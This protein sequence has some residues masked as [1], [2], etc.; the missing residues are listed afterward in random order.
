MKW[1]TFPSAEV[2]VPTAYCYNFAIMLGL[3]DNTLADA[4]ELGAAS[5]EIAYVLEN[6]GP[7]TTMLPIV[8]MKIIA[9][10]EGS[11]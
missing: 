7:K 10:C 3:A 5:D 8:F 11:I 1:A 2:M 9:G 6:T 4:V